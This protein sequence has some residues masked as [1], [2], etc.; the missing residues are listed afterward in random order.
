MIQPMLAGKCTDINKLKYPVYATPKIDG[1]R[2]IKWDGKLMSRNAKPI[3]N[4][5]I[6]EQ[7]HNLKDKLDGELVTGNFSRSSSDIMSEDGEP[8]FRY[9]VFDYIGS[10]GY[11]DRT[12]KLKQIVH[13]RVIVLMPEKINSP[14][15]LE[16][17]ERDCLAAGYEGVMVR[18]ANSPYKF[19]RS[20]EKEGYLL[21]IKRFEDSEAKI[22][23]A[24]E[25][26]SKHTKKSNKMG[27]LL[28]KDIK[29]G[30]EFE[31]GSGFTEQQRID[32]WK[33]LP[34]GKIVKYKFQPV[35]AKDKPRFPVFL[36]IRDKEDM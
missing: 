21:K 34:K 18:T 10:E 5:F 9:M 2:A 22:L 12:S 29:S 30:V 25:L 20:T 26:I 23:S 7:L 4:K 24:V 32:F 11:L 13:P 28:V 36:G 35:G 27:A 16:S 8:A 3:R 33:K 17:Y 19:G 15:H 31:L 1:I 6:Q 14:E